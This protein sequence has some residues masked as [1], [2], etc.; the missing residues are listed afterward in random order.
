VCARLQTANQ[1][2]V[3]P[4]SFRILLNNYLNKAEVKSL[5]PDGTPC[6]GAT[7]GL[8]LR[9]KIIAGD[10]VPVG[11]ETDRCWEQ[12]EDPSMVDSQGHVFQKLGK[13][14]IASPT[15]IKRWTKSGVR[16]LMKLSGLSQKAVYSILRGEAVRLNTLEVVRRSI[17]LVIA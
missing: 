16:Q 10:L 15:E 7:Q 9:A 6:N 2:K 5:A 3:L 13:M 11:K 12:G 17:D 8:L 14:A 1:D 4:D